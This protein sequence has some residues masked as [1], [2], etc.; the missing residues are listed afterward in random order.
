VIAETRALDRAHATDE[1][2]ATTSALA[3]IAKVTKLAM[4]ATAAK[5]ITTMAAFKAPSQSHCQ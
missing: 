5:A 2:G 1:T 3:T 4:N